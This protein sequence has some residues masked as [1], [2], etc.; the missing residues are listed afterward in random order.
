[1]ARFFHVEFIIART[2]VILG[3]ALL[4]MRLSVRHVVVVLPLE[5]WSAIRPHQQ[6]RNLFAIGRAGVRRIVEGIAAVSGVAPSRVPTIL[7]R[8]HIS[9]QWRAE[10][11]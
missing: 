1:M 8:T 4:V 2:S 10:R 6:M 9:V 5:L 3:V 11:S 7:L